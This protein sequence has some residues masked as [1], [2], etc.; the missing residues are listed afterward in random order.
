MW[1]LKKI[2][3]GALIDKTGIEKQRQRTNIWTPKRKGG[4]GMSWK[5]RIDTIY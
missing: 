2:G 4:D 1:N 3:V 5:I